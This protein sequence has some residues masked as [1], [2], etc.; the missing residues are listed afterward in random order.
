MSVW[1]NLKI[2]R[3]EKRFNL[4]ER[5]D[6]GPGHERRSRLV[7]SDVA[8]RADAA[9]EELDATGLRNFSLV[10]EALGLEVGRVAVE[11]VDVG[12]IDVDVLKGAD[13]R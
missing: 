10:F 7:E 4:V 5:L 2:R 1:A 9:D 6:P 8:V 11:D 3:L 12:G 13:V